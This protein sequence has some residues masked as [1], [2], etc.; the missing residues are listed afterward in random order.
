MATDH[1]IVSGS[2][3]GPGALNLFLRQLVPELTMTVDGF[4][5]SEV[6]E[7]EYLADLDFAVLEWH[8]L[9]PFNRFFLRLHLDQPEPRN[10][11]LGFPKR[12]VD[13]GPLG[14]GESDACT[15]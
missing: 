3:Q 11:L 6:F 15:F 2:A 4:A 9:D 14:P 12:P 8:A 13:D 7:L 1:T 5:R 10:E